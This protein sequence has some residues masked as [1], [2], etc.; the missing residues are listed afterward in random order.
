M[1]V[2]LHC[3]DCLEVLGTFEPDTFDSCVTDPPYHF[4]SI[5]KRFGADDAAPAK[6]GKTGAYKRASAGFM[7]KQWDGGDI[8]FRPE[9]WAAVYRV[10][11][12]GAHLVAFGAP[13]NFHRLA[14]AIEDAGFEIRD[15]LAWLFGSG[16]PK[17]HDV[18]KGID[19]AAGAEREIVGT[20]ENWGTRPEIG[21]SGHKGNWNISIA[22]TDSAREWSGW[23]TAS[24]RIRGGGLFR[25]RAGA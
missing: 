1:N 9:T 16:F 4:A 21:P 20:S 23:G 17:S 18:S 25:R 15:T 19:R 22:A 5:V 24:R 10:L 13:K 3:G 11:K 7:G 2:L 6:S 14:C 12:P 8:A